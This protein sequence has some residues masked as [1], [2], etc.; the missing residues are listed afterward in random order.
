MS[1]APTSSSAWRR[2]ATRCKGW[3][4]GGQRPAASPRPGAPTRSPAAMSSATPT[5]LPGQRSRSAPGQGADEGR[6]AAHCPQHR[7]AAGA[8]WE[9]RAR[10]V[11]AHDAKC[12]S[13]SRI[14]VMMAIAAILPANSA[15]HRCQ[16]LL[17][18]GQPGFWLAM[19]PN[20]T[21]RRKRGRWR[22]IST[23]AILVISCP[24][25][26]L[27]AQ[28]RR[29]SVKWPVGAS[30]G[31]YMLTVEEFL[32]WQRSIDRHG[33]AG[34]RTTR[35]QQYRPVVPDRDVPPG[36]RSAPPEIDNHHA[37]R[38]L[39]GLDYLRRRQPNPD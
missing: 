9:G 4:P 20:L 28:A 11:N 18:P 8:P 21:G 10:D 14:T 2:A 25:L 6:G 39:A 19:R 27:D 17:R 33:L 30:L 32:A 22:R 29:R 36:Q 31:R 5:G 13:L 1:G 3:S 37:E 12:R 26:A 23:G 24:G 34:L 35:I 16:R 7:A 15:G 38:T